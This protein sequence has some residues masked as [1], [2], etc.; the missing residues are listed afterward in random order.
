VTSANK[1]AEERADD[2]VVRLREGAVAWRAI[3]GEI[4]AL[5]VESSTYIAANRTGGVLWQRLTEGATEQALVAELMSRYD[6][7]AAQAQSDVAAF[8]A[9]LAERGLLEPTWVSPAA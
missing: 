8:L 1:D 7:E 2:A 9:A 3:D 4:V 5:E 6:I